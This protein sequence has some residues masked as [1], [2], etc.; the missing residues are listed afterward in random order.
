MI[1]FIFGVV[2]PACVGVYLVVW[3]WKKITNLINK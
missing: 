2:L 3:A 1:G